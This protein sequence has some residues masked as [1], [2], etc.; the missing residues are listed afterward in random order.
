MLDVYTIE[1]IIIQIRNLQPVKSSGLHELY[2][3]TI[4][5]FSFLGLFIVS[6]K[7]HSEYARQERIRT[8]A[9]YAD[10]SRELNISSNYA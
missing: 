6:F 5:F 7:P 9:P 8:S 10:Q 3:V 1:R 4:F 2:T